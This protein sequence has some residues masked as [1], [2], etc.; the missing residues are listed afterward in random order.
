MPPALCCVLLLG[1]SR[2]ALRQVDSRMA[3]RFKA[4][5]AKADAAKRH[6]QQQQQQPQQFL[7][8]PK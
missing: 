1:L 5:K 8:A 3:A 2:R 7:A 4:N 6:H